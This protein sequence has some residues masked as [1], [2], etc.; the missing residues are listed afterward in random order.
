MNIFVFLLSLIILLNI[1]SPT[2]AQIILPNPLYANNFVSLVCGI[3][4]YIAG[5]VGALAV[6]MFIWAGILFLTSAGNE[7]QLTK[8][9]KAVLWATIG[10]AIALAGGGLIQLVG[11]IIGGG[12]GTTC[13]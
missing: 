9:R 6:I 4:N 5:F 13:P 1:A 7:G 2:L 11:M 12:A 3:A 10:L 8:A